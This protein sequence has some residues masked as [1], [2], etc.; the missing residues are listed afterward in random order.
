[1]QSS[2]RFDYAGNKDSSGTFRFGGLM[3][4]SNVLMMTNT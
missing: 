3:K 1:M 2:L 4:V